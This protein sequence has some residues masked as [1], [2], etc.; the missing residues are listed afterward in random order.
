MEWIIQ[1]I[2][3][4]DSIALISLLSPIVF[5]WA[6]LSTDKFLNA[7]KNMLLISFLFS[8]IFSFSKFQCE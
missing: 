4:Y 7:S 6:F 1:V 2:Q 8:P 5:F 3:T